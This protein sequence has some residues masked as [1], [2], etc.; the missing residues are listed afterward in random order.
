MDAEQQSF[1]LL[2]LLLSTVLVVP[3]F[4]RLGLGS[5]LGYLAA[6]LRAFTSTHLL[7]FDYA[8]RAFC[9]W[10]GVAK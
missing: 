9:A 7:R 1:S 5:V 4:K 2:V 3:L 6:G 8:S 10:L